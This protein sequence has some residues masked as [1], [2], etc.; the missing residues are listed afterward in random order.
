[1]KII[2]ITDIAFVSYNSPALGL[3]VVV[4]LNLR[5]LDYKQVMMRNVMIMKVLGKNPSPDP[6][7]QM[8][9]EDEYHCEEIKQVHG[10]GER[11]RGDSPELKRFSQL[12]KRGGC[13]A[14]SLQS[15]CV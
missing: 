7:T 12:S 3:A 5:L 4:P 11:E 13:F 15:A 1:M 6:W 2:L 14:Q 8:I 10:I 9:W